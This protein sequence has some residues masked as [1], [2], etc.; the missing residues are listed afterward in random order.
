MKIAELFIELY[1][2][3]GSN[4]HCY[5]QDLAWAWK[6]FTVETGMPAP[7]TWLRDFGARC[8]VRRASQRA[9]LA[10]LARARSCA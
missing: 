10:R 9:T 1:L 7:E 4:E 3:K 6:V 5:V 8:R 2:V